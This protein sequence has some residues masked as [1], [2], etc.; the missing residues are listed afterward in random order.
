MIHRVGVALL[1][2]SWALGAGRSSA[3]DERLTAEPGPRAG[4]FRGVRAAA[5]SRD[6]RWM[7]LEADRTVTVHSTADGAQRLQFDDARLPGDGAFA[8]DGRRLILVRGREAQVVEVE[9]G[10]VVARLQVKPARLGAKNNTHFAAHPD[11][12]PC[13]AFAPDGKTVA[14]CSG[15]L[16]HNFLDLYDADTGA[17]LRELLND[18]D[19]LPRQIAF[20][21][22]GKTLFAGFW[23]R[24]FVIALTPDFHSPGPPDAPAAAAEDSSIDAGSGQGPIWRTL[25][26]PIQRFWYGPGDRESTAYILHDGRVTPFPLRPKLARREPLPHFPV[27]PGADSLTVIANIGP[28]GRVAV[29]DGEDVS[30]RDL[31]GRELARLPGKAYASRPTCIVATPDGSTCLVGRANGFADLW[32]LRAP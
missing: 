11:F 19:G 2:A 32:T 21:P 6:G 10:E 18:V 9:R 20:E 13:A 8:P 4:A 1:F 15:S 23:S 25:E 5:L 24:N 3:E 27:A 14:L 31:D 22:N 17:P 7:A 30:I 12:S 26:Q 28:S 29:A 16:Y